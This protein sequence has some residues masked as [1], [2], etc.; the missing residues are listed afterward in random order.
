MSKTLNESLEALFNAQNE[1]VRMKEE[2]VTTK[3][4]IVEDE[5]S[6]ILAERQLENLKE[7]GIFLKEKVCKTLYT[8]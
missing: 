7:I 8:C 1:N 2:M 5:K 6:K 4:K 3:E